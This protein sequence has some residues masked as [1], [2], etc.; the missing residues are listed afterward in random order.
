MQR[1]QHIFLWMFLVLLLEVFWIVCTHQL[2]I[3][4]SAGNT[5]KK[6][7][8]KETELFIQEELQCF[9]V[10]IAYQSRLYFLDSY[11]ADRTNGMHEGCDIMDQENKPGEI[12]V[13][14]AAQGV[15][16]NVGWLY[17]GGYR[18]GITSANGI[19]YYYAH[20]DS[21]AAGLY[22]G[23]EIKAGELLGFMG[24]TGEGE[25]GTKGKFDTHLHFGIYTKDEEGNERSVNPYPFLLEIGGE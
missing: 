19:Y 7:I 10:P 23:K 24:N 17:L 21:Y 18:V 15:I 11:G 8:V 6:R 5:E 20:L 13:I 12:P 16:T 4:L 22:I 25:E 14:S 1:K 9:P 2:N 3:R